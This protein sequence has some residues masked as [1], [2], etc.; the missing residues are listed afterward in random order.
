MFRLLLKSIILFGILGCGTMFDKKGSSGSSERVSVPKE[1]SIEIPKILR[2]DIDTKEPQQSQK[3]EYSQNISKGYRELKN[4]IENVVWSQ[5]L[6]NINLL[7]AQR[8]IKDVDSRCRK[9]KLNSICIIDAG[10]LSFVFDQKFILDMSRIVGESV[11]DDFKDIKDKLIPLGQVEFTQYDKKEE[12]QYNLK[13]DSS[14]ISAFL[15][16]DEVSIQTLKWSEE[17]NRVLTILDEE[18]N[19]SKEVLTI[20]YLKKDS[21][22]KEM[23][24]KNLYDSSISID[25]STFYLHLTDKN[26]DNESF[27]IN[28]NYQNLV[29]YK[30]EVYIDH[31]ISVG[32]ISTKG[33]FLDIYG[34]Y[35]NYNL[36]KEKYLFDGNGE[37]LSSQYCEENLVCDMSDPSTWLDIDTIE[38]LPNI[39]LRGSVGGLSNNTRYFIFAPNVDI[40]DNALLTSEN[41]DTLLLSLVGDIYILDNILYGELFFDQYVDRLDELVIA[42][43]VREGDNIYIEVVSQEDRPALK[44]YTE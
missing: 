43:S 5:K 18:D 30:G 32:E 26:D 29:E 2:K 39:I 33:G 19:I 40:E 37:I 38:S 27:D 3:E 15:G 9:E 8:I 20:S 16:E 6:A 31:S 17:K 35:L 7:F 28:S 4:S 44:I 25:Q 34:N 11:E 36:F 42:R 21:G 41:Q 22:E 24:M 1:I 23:S 14:P 12:Y 10:E 13:I